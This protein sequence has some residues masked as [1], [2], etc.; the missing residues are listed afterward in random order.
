MGKPTRHNVLFSEPNFS[1]IAVPPLYGARD[2]SRV[3]VLII[4]GHSD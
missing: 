3:F 2:G 1:W 4:L